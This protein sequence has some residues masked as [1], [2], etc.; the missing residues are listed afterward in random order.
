MRR[1]YFVGLIG[2][3][4]TLA[5]A[6]SDDDS[7]ANCPNVTADSGTPTADG[8]G[9]DATTTSDATTGGG[10]AGRD[11]DASEGPSISSE[12]GA[13]AEILLYSDVLT[14]EFDEDDTVL[15]ASDASECVAHVRAAT[16]PPSSG[17]KL[18]VGG[19]VV[20]ADGGPPATIE[21][22]PDQGNV[23]LYFDP[24]SAAFPSNDLLELQV[25]GAGTESVPAFPVQTLR[26]PPADP[27]AVTA[28]VAGSAALS[29]PSGE[30]LQ[31]TWTPPTGA[32]ADVQM[33][34]NMVVSTASKKARLYCSFPVTA[35]TGKVPASLLTAVK[36]R[37][38]L[39]AFGQIVLC[40][41]GSKEYKATGASYVIQTMRSDAEF[42]RNIELK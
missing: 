39:P 28:P 6:C 26:T 40:G 1:Y 33:N 11:A 30:A 15:H 2:L 9:K 3:G 25:Q 42:R 22:T 37:I 10:D 32:Q 23:Y 16:K 14:A 12:V 5:I 38:G 36:N 20:G 18:T 35:G 17:G 13:G 41:G 19:P 8:G 4:A 21:M 31:I 27:I 34:V 7:P 24:S 29:V